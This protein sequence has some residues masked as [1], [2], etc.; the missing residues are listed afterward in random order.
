MPKKIG[1]LDAQ[2][3][4]AAAR[5][6]DLLY[7]AITHAPFVEKDMP[8]SFFV[9]N[10]KGNWTDCGRADWKCVGMTIVKVPEEKML[11]ISEDGEV[12]TYVSGRITNEQIVPRPVVLRGV[13]TIEGRA[14]AFG[15]RRQAYIRT[16]E[17]AWAPMHA[18]DVAGDESAG[19]EALCGFSLK[20]IYAFGWRGEIWLY[21]GKTWSQKGSPTNVILTGATVHSD[22]YVYAVG[23]NGTILKGRHDKWSVVAAG[24]TTEDLWGIDS[25]KDRI[26][27]A[28]FSTLY[29]L[30]GGTLA[31]EKL[32]ASA[33]TFRVLTH[34]D[35]DLWSVGE[36]DV[37]RSTGKAWTVVI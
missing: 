18:P 8:H 32:P 29:R 4:T 27:I 24:E 11:A 3:L 17:G 25:F 23:Q 22:G 9:S 35:D 16:D 6:K 30:N 10:W 19:F 2:F 36:E 26:F 1:K 12:H 7:A 13:S 37:L 34:A 31:E 21:D 28:S 20:E 33:S 14:I 5:F 15:M